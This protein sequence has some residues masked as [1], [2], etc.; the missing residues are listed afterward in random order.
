[1]QW[2]IELKDMND[3]AA[4][5]DNLAV[6]PV[7]YICNVVRNCGNSE[8][9]H[10]SDSLSHLFFSSVNQLFPQ[11]VIQAPIIY[12]ASFR[13]LY[14]IPFQGKSYATKKKKMWNTFDPGAPT[15]RLPSWSRLG[16]SPFNPVLPLLAS[17]ACGMDA[18]GTRT[19]NH[20]SWWP[21]WFTSKRAPDSR[22]G[23]FFERAKP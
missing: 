12:S 1:M 4:T 11:S 16:C 15:S 10:V 8:A 20:A 17:Q 13:S 19:R 9:K 7:N 23:R 18:L 3:G 21:P 14:Y 2:F 22:N 6:K 5:G